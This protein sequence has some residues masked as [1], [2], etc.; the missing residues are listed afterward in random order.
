LREL[1]HASLN[2]GIVMQSAVSCSV[3]QHAVLLLNEHVV[4]GSGER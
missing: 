3:A 4:Y 1:Q 2:L